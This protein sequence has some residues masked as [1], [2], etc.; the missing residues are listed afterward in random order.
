MNKSCWLLNVLKLSLVFLLLSVSFNLSAQSIKGKVTD[1]QTGETLPG[2]TIVVDNTSRGT[3][4]DNEGNYRISLSP[5]NYSLTI[6][7]I[8][9]KT[10][11][12]NIKVE[13]GKD[14]EINFRME[15]ADMNLKEVEVVGR[16]NRESENILLLE[17]KQALLATQAVG[18]KE[19]SRKGAGNAEAAVAKVSGIS[20][21][22]G[23]KN[24]FVRGLGDRYNA[25]LLNGFP[26]PS[27]DPE[28]K[29][30][31]LD[32]FSADVIQS[33]GVNKVFSS[34]STADVGG[35]VIEIASKELVG[36]H[37]LSI[38]ASG[39]INTEAIKVDF[40]R[41]DGSNYFGFANSTQPSSEKFDFPNSLDL[42]VVGLPLNHSYGIS[43]GKLFNLGEKRNPLSFFMVATHSTDY[44]YT[45]E[46]VRNTN[47][48]GNITQDQVGDR[49]SINTSQLILANI[50]FSLNRSHSISYNFMAIHANNQYVGEYS[51]IDIY[52]FED[53]GDTF[54]FTR[55]QQTN[56]NLLLIHQL[57]STFSL[58][59]K[60]KW[61]VGASYNSIKGNEPDRRQNNLSRMGNNSDSW[62]EFTT[63]NSQSRFFS[64]LI[65]TDANVKTSLSFKLN[66]SFG[67]KNSQ[68]L[69][70]YAGRF[71]HDS[72]DGVE[73]NYYRTDYLG[74]LDLANIKVDDYFNSSYDKSILDIKKSGANV[75][76]VDKTINSFFADATY[77]FLQ[78]FVA[79]VG[80]KFDYVY[81]PINYNIQVAGKGNALIEK[82]YFLPSLNL[83]YDLNEKNTLRLGTSKTYTLPQ[84]KEV[85]PYQ[86]VNVSFTSQGNKDLKPSDNYNVD[87]KWDLYLS[88]SELISVGGYYKYINKPIGRVEIGNSAGILTYDNISNFA[89]VAGFE[90]ELKKNIVNLID[91][92][93]G[94]T[95]RFSLGVN[96]SYLYSYLETDIL[97][98]QKRKTQLEGAA[99]FIVNADI[100][101]NYTNNDKV[102]TTSIVLNYFS[103]RIYTLGTRDYD[104]IM[105]K[106]VFS[107]DFVS[108]FKLNNNFTI[109]L[110]AANLTDSPYR[111]TRKITKTNENIILNEYRKGMNISLGLSYEL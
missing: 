74:R 32:F 2:V 45:K 63:G 94:K 73:Y 93:S 109:K 17:Q 77:Q 69:V 100:L 47:V 6:S 46:I 101:Y 84:S 66:D 90:V 3:N 53:S 41:Q 79:N 108:S 48:Q 59:D 39:G 5:G 87:L 70:G 43:G 103:D 21:Q 80:L 36:D 71:V 81:I 18:A 16:S 13:T 110:K 9:Y 15:S 98:T 24:V 89:N 64:E 38:D 105:E 34:T 56:D 40:L 99:P 83:K 91:A 29:N 51:G 78:G 1:A 65:E 75:Y 44:S 37:A 25:T 68:I 67:G 88:P 31:A 57:I 10:I 72:F 86:Y 33:I 49:Y 52:K 104:D 96:A 111:L 20:K 61:N 92:I 12:Q 97:N 95:N 28:Y 82:E 35:A 8:S 14:T 76:N 22:D 26:I 19:M 85:S 42:S 30:I 55:R 23:V 107:L 11:N 27:E 60:L 58:S 54:G 106:G 50:A 4:T 7:Y 62:Y 102:F